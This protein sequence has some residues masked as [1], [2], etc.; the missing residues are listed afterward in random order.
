MERH[1]KCLEFKTMK[2]SF[3]D[4]IENGVKASCPK[5]GIKGMK[6]DACTHMTCDNC[7]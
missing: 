6:D 4:I 7:G 3:E 1:F 2:D 5:C